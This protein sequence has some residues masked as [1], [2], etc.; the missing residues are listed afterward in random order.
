MSSEPI[1]EDPVVS[2]ADADI[3]T[4]PKSKHRK[5]RKK[6]K[7]KDP[8]SE[9]NTVEMSKNEDIL[10]MDELD[11]MMADIELENDKSTNPQ[12][13]STSKHKEHRKRSESK[14]ENQEIKD[15]DTEP[16]NEADSKIERKS[17][18]KSASKSKSKSDS[19]RRS[20]HRKHPERK[21]RKRRHRKEAE[22]AQHDI[23]AVVVDEVKIENIESSPNDIVQAFSASFYITKNVDELKV[24]S[25]SR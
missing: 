2:A 11:K 19:K 4:A 9:I 24:E 15:N 23:D 10:P 21:G 16:Q 18:S 22:E 3:D 8:L 1:N 5:S 20:K 13:E 7:S 6:S 12:N 25:I 17:E 14:A